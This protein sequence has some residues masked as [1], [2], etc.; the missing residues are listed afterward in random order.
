MAAAA[1]RVNWMAIWIS[2]AVVVVVVVV[3]G[4]AIW[5]NRMALAL[6]ESPGTATVNEETG[7]ITIGEGENVLEEYMD[8][9]C[10]FCGQY[11]EGYGE[12][13][14]Q[15]V[16]DGQIT[17][18]IHPIAIL[19][20]QS[21]GTNYSTRAASAVYCVAD[22][23][24]EAVYPF[25]DALYKNQPSEGSSGL[26][27]DALIGYAHDAGASDAVDECITGGEYADYVAARTQ[28]VPVAPGA[29]GV[30][31]PTIILNDEFVELS[32][33]PEADILSKLK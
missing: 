10:P 22:D 23:N 11:Q 1:R 18:Q 14:A 8:F 19:D 28:E 25:I 5:M 27:D 2:V 7:A 17:L 24:A 32:G 16:E 3:A 26:D 21:Q 33:G 30:S 31:T 29:S 15:A 9:M 4:F 13:I 20:S 12:E 6:A